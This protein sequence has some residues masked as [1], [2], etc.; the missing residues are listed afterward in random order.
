MLCLGAQSVM[1]KQIK[2]KHQKSKAQSPALFAATR[3][4]VYV[5]PAVR[6]YE[7]MAGWSGLGSRLSLSGLPTEMLLALMSWMSAASVTARVHPPT[8]AVSVIGELHLAIGG[9]PPSLTWVIQVFLHHAE[10]CMAA[11]KEALGCMGGST[12]AC[13]CC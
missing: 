5:R 8:V 12:D 3:E 11:W 9:A 1:C 7:V 4:N 2:E 10:K 6:V 13:T